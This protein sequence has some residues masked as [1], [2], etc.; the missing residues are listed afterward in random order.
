MLIIGIFSIVAIRREV[1]SV[2]LLSFEPAQMELDTGTSCAV[3][4]TTA[5]MITVSSMIWSAWSILDICES[6]KYRPA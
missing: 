1:G 3:Y 2:S 4:V 6:F 5:D